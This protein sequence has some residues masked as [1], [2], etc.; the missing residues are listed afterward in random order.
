MVNILDVVQYTSGIPPCFSCGRHKE[1]RIGGL[2]TARGEAAHTLDI[3]PE[4]F[5]KWEND[6]R[7]VAW[8]EA[9]AKKL[10]NL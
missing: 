6:P 1:C 3:K 9:A 7:T 4:Y 8:I 5:H 2:Y 10:R